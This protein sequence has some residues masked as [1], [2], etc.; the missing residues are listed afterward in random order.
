VEYGD[1]VLKYGL[2]NSN[3]LWK[4]FM[5]GVEGNVQRRNITIQ[6][7]DSAGSKPVMSW[8]LINAWASEWSGAHLDTLGKEIA[9]E[10][11]TIVYENLTREGGDG[12]KG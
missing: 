1:I 5:S 10:S 7:M 11:L 12:A 6:L 4:W 2:T 8:N 9:I 3:A